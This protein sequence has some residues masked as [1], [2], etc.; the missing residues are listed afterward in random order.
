[1]SDRHD[2][3]VVWNGAEFEPMPLV[4]ASLRMEPMT[5]AK[6]IKLAKLVN[7]DIVT[8]AVA[9]RFGGETA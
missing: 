5:E 8:A 1:M 4:R 6:A 7:K 9:R 3:T 2:W